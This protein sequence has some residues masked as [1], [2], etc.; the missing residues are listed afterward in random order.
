MQQPSEL[1]QAIRARQ[2]GSAEAFS[3]LWVVIGQLTACCCPSLVFRP[4][5]RQIYSGALMLLCW[6]LLAE[7]HK[8]CCN[9]QSTTSDGNLGRQIIE[10]I[11]Q[12]REIFLRT[13][14]DLGVRC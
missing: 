5:P 3:A 13:L 12:L 11:L 14:N 10:V 2:H 8:P 4:T 1:G 9:E 7:F 6:Q